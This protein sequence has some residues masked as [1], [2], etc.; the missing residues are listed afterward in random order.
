MAKQNKMMVP[1]LLGGG[2]LALLFMGG[3]K[4]SAKT[5]G[6]GTGTGGTGQ[7]PEAGGIDVPLPGGEAPN[8]NIPKEP[9]KVDP[10]PVTTL[11]QQNAVIVINE[12]SLV[13]NI[14]PDG[15]GDKKPGQSNLDWATN[16][17]FWLSYSY[18]DIYKVQAPNLGFG[19]SAFYG[20]DPVP[21]K[22]T[23]G[24]AKVNG[25]GYDYWSQVWVRI[26]N[27]LKTQYADVFK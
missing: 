14:F 27:Y 16:M 10:G 12:A 17:V 21:Y 19:E 13:S 4:A 2:L 23:K 22:L 9:K 18:P 24:M 5:S 11:E 1:I 8:Q 26:R 15:L 6:A 3:K 25:K 7:L 20:G